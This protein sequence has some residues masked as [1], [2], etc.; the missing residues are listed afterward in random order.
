MEHADVEP[1]VAAGRLEELEVLG[2]RGVPGQEH[3]ARR[4]RGFYAGL[5]APPEAFEENW[6]ILDSFETGFLWFETQAMLRPAVSAGDELDS[7]A[8]ELARRM[9]ATVSE[10]AYEA[11]LEILVNGLAARLPGSPTRP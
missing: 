11:G 9:P 5:G 1:P 2:H 7:E 6:S 8:S 4:L 3:Y 10:G